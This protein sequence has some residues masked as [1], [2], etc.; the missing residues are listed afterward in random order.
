MLL[1]RIRADRLAAMRARDDLRRNLLGTLLAAAAKDDK[2]P[3]DARVART[4]RVFLKSVE[5]TT[6]LLEARGLD[7]GPQRAERAILEAYLPR[8]LSEDELRASVEEVVADLPERS[9]GAMG[10]AMAALKARHGEAL[11]ARAASAL[12]RAALAEAEP[13]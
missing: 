9:P 6:G 3:D 8:A 4:I 7:A 12:V 1:D 5:E 11:D 2:S 10:R 13:G